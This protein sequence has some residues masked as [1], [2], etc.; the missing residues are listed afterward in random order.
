MPEPLPN[1]SVACWLS[2]ISLY[3]TT[4][5]IIHLNGLPVPLWKGRACIIAREGLGTT[6]PD[7]LGLQPRTE[8]RNIL[9]HTGDLLQDAV[10]SSSARNR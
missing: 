4:L 2:F 9:E 5:Q 6:P 7:V 1:I 10:V 8:P 3:I